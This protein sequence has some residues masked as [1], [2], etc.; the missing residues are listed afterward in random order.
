MIIDGL[1]SID[2]RSVDGFQGQE[3]DIII[4]SATRSNQHGQI[5]FLSDPRRLNVALT[6]AKSSCWVVGDGYTLH[7][8]SGSELWK[9]LIQDA[10]SR[11]VYFEE[12]PV[13]TNQSVMAK[14]LKE[15]VGEET[16][17]Q[18]CQSQRTAAPLPNEL[19]IM[20]ENARWK[21]LVSRAALDALRGVSE[22]LRK[23]LLSVASQLAS[24]FKKTSFSSKDVGQ[25]KK[26][27]RWVDW[28]SYKIVWSVGLDSTD[29]KQCIR[30]WN[31]CSS[32]DSDASLRNIEK[33]LLSHS[34]EYLEKW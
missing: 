11:G 14:K 20:F 13:A 18:Y 5:G 4:F 33:I 34:P 32:Q 3:R 24:G 12:Q 25:Y 21:I 10:K 22:G 19:N 17:W 8:S 16:G 7:R 1:T 27:L 26:L 30:I 9:S 23:S 29:Y 15:I 6:R 31:I 2:V 28:Q